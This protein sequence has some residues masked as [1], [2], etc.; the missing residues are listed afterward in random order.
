M[1]IY[2]ELDGIPGHRI[3]ITFKDKRENK[4]KVNMSSFDYSNQH[5]DIKIAHGLR[6]QVTVSDT[7]KITFNHS[8]ESADKTRSIVNNVGRALLKKKVLMPGSKELIQLTK[9]LPMT[10]IRTFT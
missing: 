9:Q 4:S 1:N 6:D 8:I 5:I 10:L 7:V 2:G 3:Q